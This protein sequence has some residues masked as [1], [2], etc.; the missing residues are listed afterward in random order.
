MKTDLSQPKDESRR[1]LLPV[2]VVVAIAALIVA[3]GIG[4]VSRYAGVKRLSDVKLREHAEFT[5]LKKEF[6]VKKNAI[7]PFLRKAYVS[8]KGLS[9]IA[10][11]EEL[12]ALVGVKEKITT[13]KAVKERSQMD[14][15]ING[16]ELNI[17]GMSLNQLVNLIYLIENHRMLLVVTEMNLKSRFDAPELLDVQLK[18]THLKSSNK[19]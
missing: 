14:F 17:N 1:K 4:A 10:V 2:L 9:T 19:S 7:D 8:S 18:V 16:V 11:V 6:L 5:S 13:L 12:G 15:T 3:I